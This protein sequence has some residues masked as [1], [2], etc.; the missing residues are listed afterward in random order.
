MIGIA[1]DLPRRGLR[2]QLGRSRARP[3]GGLPK[4]NRSSITL[5]QLASIEFIETTSA[6]SAAS[7]RKL[8]GQARKV[9]LD[10]VSS[11]SYTAE[12]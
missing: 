4:E 6:K 9:N 5:P 8:R 2:I 1:W 7:M 12:R 11:Y 10:A 3:K